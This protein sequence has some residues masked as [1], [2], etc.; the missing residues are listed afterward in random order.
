ML[1]RSMFPAFLDQIVRGV[2]LAA[3]VY[4]SLVAATYWAIRARRLSPFGALP[5][6]VRRA[7]EPMLRPLERRMI[8]AGGNPQNAPYWLFGIVV[9]GGLILISLTGW[10]INVVQSLRYVA[11]SGPR[12]MMR[13]AVGGLFSLLM[14]ALLIR[15]VASWF[16]VSP[17]QRWMRPIVGL[18]E[19]ILEPLRRV[20]PP[21][22]IIDFKIGRASCRERV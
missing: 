7:S 21:F 16:G 14:V 15:V 1:F 3:L 18:T 4:A 2:V 17:Y 5:R 8:R 11:A 12:D 6:L 9:V 22:G 20:L 10:L 13:F 19:W